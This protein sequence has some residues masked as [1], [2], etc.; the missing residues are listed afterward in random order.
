M[1]LGFQ[2]TG[3]SV[4]YELQEF[5]LYATRGPWSDTHRARFSPVCVS[6]F[7]FLI[8]WSVPHPTSFFFKTSSHLTGVIIACSPPPP[9]ATVSSMGSGG[10]SCCVL[11]SQHSGNSVFVQWPCRSPSPVRAAGGRGGARTGSGDRGQPVANRLSLLRSRSLQTGGSSMSFYRKLVGGGG[12][13]PK[14]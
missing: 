9:T 5:L 14:A 4:F 8:V 6:P 2:K 11:S 7:H 13:V 1:C 12:G 3:L 10:L